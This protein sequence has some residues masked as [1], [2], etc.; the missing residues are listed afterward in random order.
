M[1]RI[2]GVYG[3][4]RGG[5]IEGVLGVYRVYVVC[6]YTRYNGCTSMY[7]RQYSV[8]KGYNIKGITHDGS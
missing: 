3:V 2:W 5:V 6:I 1:G 7:I 8:Y 4:F